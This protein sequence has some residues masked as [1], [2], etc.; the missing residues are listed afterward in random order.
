MRDAGSYFVEMNPVE[1]N[2]P[3]P[4]SW[5]VGEAEDELSVAWAFPRDSSL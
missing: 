2:F 3:R 4:Q 5:F 1:T